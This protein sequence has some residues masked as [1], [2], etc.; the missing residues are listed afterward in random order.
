MAP[1]EK[2]FLEIVIKSIDLLLGIA[3]FLIGFLIYKKGIAEYRNSNKV[4]RAEFLEKLIQDFNGDA[5]KVAKYVLD[6][7]EVKGRYGEEL[8]VILRNHKTKDINDKTE[9]EIRASFDML[10]DFFIKLSYY[11]QN[12][13]ITREELIY[14]RYY[15]RKISISDWDS[16]ASDPKKEG[17]RIFINTYYD[18]EPFVYLFKEVV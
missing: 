3:T 17:V 2:E 6:D 4:K 14:F 16:P 11:R 13:L 8:P 10:L 5:L 12:D 9:V 7:F 1:T 15:I 18:R